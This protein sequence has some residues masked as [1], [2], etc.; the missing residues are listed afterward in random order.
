MS[1]FKIKP[2]KAIGNKYTVEYSPYG[3]L[4]KR[5]WY[6]ILYWDKTAWRPR[7][8]SKER[9]EQVCRQ[10]DSQFSAFN[11]QATTYK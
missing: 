8:F 6:K 9:A 5:Q 2:V 3:I 7:T 10:I 1:G 4:W 11:F